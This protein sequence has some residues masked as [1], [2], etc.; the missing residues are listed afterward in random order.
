MVFIGLGLSCH[1]ASTPR[2]PL[3]VYG[4]L[5][6]MRC[7]KTNKA[8]V[9]GSEDSIVHFR[10]TDAMDVTGVSGSV[11]T[12]AHPTHVAL[13]EAIRTK[14]DITILEPLPYLPCVSFLKR[15]INS[16]P[17]NS[18]RGPGSASSLAS[19]L[20]RHRMDTAPLIQRMCQFQVSFTSSITT[21][22]HAY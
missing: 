2:T 16:D 9:R 18:T 19:K 17:M 1:G 3:Q 22:T 7:I 4:S 12:L 8:A 15:T 11:V 10:C 14:R 5:F 20:L 21:H 13:L 6:A